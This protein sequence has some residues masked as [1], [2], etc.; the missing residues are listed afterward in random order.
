MGPFAILGNP[1]R[2]SMSPALFRVAYPQLPAD[3]YRTLEVPD[4]ITGWKEMQRLCMQGVNVTMPFKA[5]FIQFVQQTEPSARE[6]N[7][8]NLV[9]L[10]KGSWTA[11]NTDVMGVVNSFIDSGTVL[12]GKHVLVIGAGGAG[13]AAALGMEQ[14]G[15]LVYMA[16]R[17]VRE[18]LYPLTSVPDLLKRCSLV[19][20]TIPWEPGKAVKTGFTSRHVIL[21][22]SYTE[23]PLKE[24]AS[25]SGSIYLNG[26]HWLYHQ[27]VE[28]FRIMTGMEPHRKAMRK[29]LGL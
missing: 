23:A 7:A 26:Y 11:C 15:A 12:S 17:T 1:V 8:T 22:A 13:R 29:L 2:S 3:T 19:I 28:G 10:N 4:A 21:D 6:I 20:N 9:Y 5:D 16:N 27:A 18:G 24:A 25:F 14:A